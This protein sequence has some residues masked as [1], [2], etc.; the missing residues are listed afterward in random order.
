MANG[1]GPAGAGA[2]RTPRSKRRRVDRHCLVRVVWVVFR[3]L[4]AVRRRQEN[5]IRM[6]RL[7]NLT[8]FDQAG[9]EQE[10]EDTEAG[11]EVG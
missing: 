1:R 2:S 11:R 3:L 4:R 6:V 10:E 9:D 5:Q 7:E 8:G